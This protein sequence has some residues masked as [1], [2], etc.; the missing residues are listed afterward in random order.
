MD[1]IENETKKYTLL[2]KWWH[3][4]LGFVLNFFFLI[5]ISFSQFGSL[6]LFILRFTAFIKENYRRVI[7]KVFIL[8]KDSLHETN[9]L[10]TSTGSEYLIL[11][12]IG[13]SGDKSAEKIIKKTKDL[14]LVKNSTSSNSMISDELENKE[15]SYI[16]RKQSTESRKSSSS[17]TGSTKSS[18]LKKKIIQ[19]DSIQSE[20][21]EKEDDN[22]DDDD[23]DIFSSDYT[24]IKNDT[25]S[26]VEN[27]QDINFDDDY[28]DSEDDFN[29]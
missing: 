16:L 17:S 4:C 25:K 5:F 1:Q 20:K 12:Q 14:P 8:G 27:S 15:N 3:V 9:N 2:E 7:N 11:E 24:K 19:S 18:I 21:I 13:W 23:D 26:L 6:V 28:G 10:N 29:K 22:E